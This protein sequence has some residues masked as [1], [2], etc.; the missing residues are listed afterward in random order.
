MHEI[1]A[2]EKLGLVAGAE[3]VLVSFLYRFAVFE[4]VSFLF[5]LE[6]GELREDPP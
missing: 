6:P 5:G 3:R 2:V 1:R 4:E